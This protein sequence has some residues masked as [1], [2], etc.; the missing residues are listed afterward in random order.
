L[1]IVVFGELMMYENIVLKK[2][3]L[4][5]ASDLLDYQ[6][7]NREFLEKLTPLRDEYFYTLDNQK[8]ILQRNIEDYEKGTNYNFYIFHKNDNLLIGHIG[9]S[10]I[11]KGVFQSCFLGYSL[12][13]DYINKGY[14]TLAIKQTVDF[15]F[16]TLSLHRIEAN[17]MPHNIASLKVLEKNNFN[18]E[19][20]AKKYLKINGKWED[21]I[22]MVLLNE[23]ID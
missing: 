6:I 8:S 13:K 11:I 19:G 5:F 3:T 20:L 18:K 10:N 9:L 12:D 23:L 4:S 15:A 16:N 21:H 14:M 22:H 2:A 1:I 7:R 17:V